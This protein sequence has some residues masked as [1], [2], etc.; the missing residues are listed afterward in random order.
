[1]LQG[2]MVVHNGITLLEPNSIYVKKGH[3]AQTL[4]ETWVIQKKYSGSLA[5]IP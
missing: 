1:M 2:E 3:V 4:H 5:R